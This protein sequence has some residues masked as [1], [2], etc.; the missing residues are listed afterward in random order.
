VNRL[1]YYDLHIILKYWE[2][3]TSALREFDKKFKVQILSWDLW[4][5]HIET[6]KSNFFYMKIINCFHFLIHNK[7]TF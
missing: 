4:I 1:Q 6:S 3:L 2:M 5:Q 7:G